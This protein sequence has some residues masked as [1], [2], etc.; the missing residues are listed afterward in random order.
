MICHNLEVH[1]RISVYRCMMVESAVTGELQQGEV[2]SPT[3]CA[4]ALQQ[5]ALFSV[6]QHSAMLL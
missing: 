1:S 2:I 5:L 3:E 4:A 6:W